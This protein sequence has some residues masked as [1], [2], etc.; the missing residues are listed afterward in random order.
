MKLMD[1]AKIG[2]IVLAS[3]TTVYAESHDSESEDMG[4]AIVEA[5]LAGGDATAGEKIFKKCKA[6]HMIGDG[7][8]NRTGPLLNGIVGSEIGANEDFKYSA[9]MAALGEEGQL[10]TI[11][12]L[13]ALLLK[14]RDF[15]EKTKM[16]FAG[17]KDEE[18]RANL[19][20]YL[21]TFAAEDDD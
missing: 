11:E 13:N 3:T 16:S 9:N 12:N 4:E 18:D 8:K 20:A 10:W 15:V 21:A 1:Y 5:A 19:I 7:A 6:C 17:L 2:A 14:P